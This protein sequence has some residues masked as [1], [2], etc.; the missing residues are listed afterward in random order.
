MLDE[1][2]EAG[3]NGP[4]AVGPSRSFPVSTAAL[5]LILLAAGLTLTLAAVGLVGAQF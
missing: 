1:Y 4:R 2:S 5:R 3:G